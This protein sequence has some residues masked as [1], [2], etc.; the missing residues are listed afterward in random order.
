MCYKYHKGF[1]RYPN[2]MSEVPLAI[3][4]MTAPLPPN[5]V[6]RLEALRRYNIL[7]TPPEES[8]DRITAL[9]A[10]L[11]G[12]PI[13]LVS[14]IDQF[15]AWFKSG[16]G[17]DSREVN[18]EDAI[19]SFALLT[20]DVF[21]VPDTQKDP[22]FACLPTVLSAGGIRFYA[23]A[24]LVTQDGF[25]LGNLCILD[26]KPHDDFSAE[27]C[28]NLADLAAMVVDQLELRLATHQVMQ[29]N[30]ALQ[31]VTQGVSTA[32]GEAFF[33]SLV[34]HLT[35]ALGVNAAY[36]SQLV[37]TDS[38]TLRTLAICLDGQIVENMEYSL[39]GTPCEEVIKQ[40]KIC[41]YPRGVQA[42]F[43]QANSL[44]EMEI[45]SYIAVPFFDSQGTP[46]GVLGMMDKKP[47]GNIQLAE[48]LLTILATR[49]TTELE[50]QKLEAERAQ[51]LAREQAARAEAEL[52]RSY[53]HSL[54][55]EA[56][57][58]IAITKGTKGS[59][60]VYEFAN[61]LYYQLV[62]KQELIG[63]SLAELFPELE[64]Q[65]IY[66]LLD[67]VIATGVPFVGK[68]LAIKLNRRGNG[69]VDEGFFNFV[70]QPKYGLDGKIEG[71]MNFAFEVTD[72]VLSRQQAELLT[73]DLRR[74]QIALSESEERYRALVIATSQ[75]VWTTNAEGCVVDDLPSWQNLTGQS[76]EAVKGWGWLNAVHPEDREHVA[77]KWMQAIETKSIYETECR[78]WTV[79]NYYRYF[80]VRG[81]PVFAEDGSLREWVGATTDI[82]DRKRAQDEQYFLT[83]ASAI[84]ASSLDYE[85]TLKSVA[86]LAVPF[87]ADWCSV[88]LLN[89]DKSINRV[90]IAH[91]D[92][93]KERFGWEVAARYPEHIDD[94]HGIANIIRNGKAEVYPYISDSDLVIG[95]RDAEHLHLLRELGLQ[96]CIIAPLALHGQILG[97]ITFITAESNRHYTEADL[98]LAEDLARRAANAIGNALLYR[99]AQRSQQ[100]AEQAAA[101]TARL[102]AITAALSEPL[103]P[104]QV[105]QGIAEQ[106]IAALNATAALVVLLTKNGTELEIACT[107]G[108]QEP[109]L[110]SWRRFSINTP[111]PLAEAVRTG[112]PIWVDTKE[113][114]IIRYPHLAQQYSY[115]N[116]YNAWISIPLV[117]EGKAV[118]GIS[119]SFTQFPQISEDDRAFILAIAQQSA[120]ALERARLYEA[121]RTA[122]A[123]AEAANRV[124]DEFLAVLSHE[125]R[126]P[127]NPILGWTRLLRTRNFDKV[128]TDKALETIERN[129]LLQTRLIE[130]L[131]DISRIMQGKISLNVSPI[132][133]KTTLEAAIETV[134]LAAEAKSIQIK[135][136]FATNVGL[137][138]GDASR[139]QQVIWNLVGNAI[140]FT[141][142]GGRVEVE[143]S[144]V[145]SENCL[146]QTSYA[147]IQVRDTGK[148]ISAAFLPHVFDYFRQA[149]GGTNRKYG[150]LGLG[151]A[152]ARH[153]V[154]MHG[155]TI[156]AESEG[157]GKGATFT[158]Q[159]PLMKV[160]APTSEPNVTPEDNFQLNGMRILVVDDELDNLELHAFMLEQYGA[161]V[162][163]AASAAEAFQ[164]LNN[165][166]LDLLVSDLGMPNEDG[167]TLIRQV[168]ALESPQK[169][170]I[171]AIAVTAYA[172]PEDSAKALAA[173][174]GAHIS[175][176]VDS[177]ELIEAIALISVNN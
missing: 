82:S 132:D 8:F 72:L 137:V 97:T 164:F 7:D 115:N 54:L 108:Y 174:F 109:I 116:N 92:P 102:Q 59:E 76:A 51:I 177:R 86:S 88:S 129:A 21:V 154:E 37:E 113:N 145:K 127:L 41:C 10:R 36:I 141:P 16:Y 112:E 42:Q 3:N 74:Q 122:R 118:G 58:S 153:L 28:S 130:D 148:G 120:Q 135:S 89:E 107:V 163:K 96:S 123:Q 30:A 17:F 169:R 39:H 69:M 2:R 144:L 79:D 65:V 162:I 138:S 66:E 14:L 50:R 1:T 166:N 155:G 23:G 167:Y 95:A 68:E 43:P 117:V 70:Y 52:Q 44:G 134:R 150:G 77:K 27:Q 142:N 25:N 5:E 18:R 158:V 176:P 67:G 81:V 140:K 29:M 57:A 106:G 139:L 152:I 172:R 80:F 124:K 46:L 26:T 83:Q 60:L 146:T 12:V 143:L 49:V 53:L 48:S 151:L 91:R 75:A 62:G 156:Y 85:S 19:C 9:A 136:L 99:E 13:A 161:E 147:Q 32:I 110:D 111:V 103:T 168:R 61:P 173:G 170:A 63:K 94:A 160:P 15:R 84:L 165:L 175:K 87:F 56:P 171:P 40:R 125:L 47:L 149:E 100:A 71:V 35:K 22:R 73:E 34:Q 126:S 31:E 133:L 20:D 11:L 6:E 4:F 33:S 157:D 90:A 64:N 55:M 114:R 119:L 93:E 38:E 121:E 105:A 128:K 78:L 159:L 24:P 101:R 104:S 131:L 45:E 98:V